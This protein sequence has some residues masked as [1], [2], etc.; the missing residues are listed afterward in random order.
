[1]PLPVLLALVVLGIGGIAVSLHLLGLAAPPGAL[2]ANQRQTI[3]CPSESS[4]LA[5]HSLRT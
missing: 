3:H 1:M 2:A 4:P 5:A